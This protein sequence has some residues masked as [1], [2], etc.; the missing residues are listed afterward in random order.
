[1]CTDD[2]AITNW[3]HIIKEIVQYHRLT[4]REEDIK[5]QSKKY[6]ILHFHYCYVCVLSFRA[7]IISY[8]AFL[9]QKSTT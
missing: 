5:Q 6:G 2:H 3:F 1:M 7:S 8:S 9:S 4:N